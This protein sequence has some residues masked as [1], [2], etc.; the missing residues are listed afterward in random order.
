M[1]KGKDTPVRIFEVIDGE[2]PKLA[3]LKRDDLAKFNKALSLYKDQKFAEAR[4]LFAVILR[5]SEN[6]NVASLYLERCELPRG[7][8]WDPKTW[9][10]VER[11]ET[12]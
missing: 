9:D 3:R 6:D 8:G 11:L 2:P 1:V 5:H 4:D 7:E 12:K 10:W